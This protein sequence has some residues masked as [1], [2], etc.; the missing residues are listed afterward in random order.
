MITISMHYKRDNLEFN[1][2][3][4]LLKLENFWCN[5]YESIFQQMEDGL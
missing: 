1:S 5:E 2:E 4:S 3:L